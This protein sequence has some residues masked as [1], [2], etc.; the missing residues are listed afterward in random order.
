[1][2][3]AGLAAA[4]HADPSG[5]L[6]TAAQ[7]LVF[8]A[9][10][11]LAIGL[12]VRVLATRLLVLAAVMLFAGLALFCGDLAMRVFGGTR[13]FPGAAPIGGMTIIAGWV[14]VV[15]CALRPHLR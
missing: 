2:G 14:I 9:P 3:V 5:R 15:L 12:W 7:M 8:H 10:V 13:L 6:E 1:M 11:F 4:A